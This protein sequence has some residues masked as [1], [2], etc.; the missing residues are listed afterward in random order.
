MNEMIRY[1]SFEEVPLSDNK[2]SNSQ[3]LV[4]NANTRLTSTNNRMFEKS[5]DSCSLF[6]NDKLVN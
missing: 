2:N 1:N 4:V 3:I 6:K 5:N